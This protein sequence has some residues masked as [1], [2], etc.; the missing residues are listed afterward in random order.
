[1]NLF[2]KLCAVLAALLGI[3]LFLLGAIGL[4]TGC[5][6]NFTLPPILGVVPALVGWGILRSVWLAWHRPVDT[7]EIR[8]DPNSPAN[9]KLGDFLT[10]Y[11]REH[12]A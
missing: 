4:F 6:A 3:A 7:F 10:D 5:K 9:Q 8:D 1:M 11:K 2:D 12:N